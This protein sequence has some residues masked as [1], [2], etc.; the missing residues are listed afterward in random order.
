MPKISDNLAAA[1]RACLPHVTVDAVDADIRG[2]AG[3]ADKAARDALAEYEATQL[4][5]PEV[6]ARVIV[7]AASAYAC[8]AGPGA[9]SLDVKLSAGK[10]ASASLRETAQETRE[11]ADRLL[12]Q[13]AKMT[14]AADYLED[15][16]A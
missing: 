10:S 9:A 13:A 7:G 16:N 6:T 3:A 1:L 11:R 14:A 4:E 8:I 15:R 2:P 5:R 12:R